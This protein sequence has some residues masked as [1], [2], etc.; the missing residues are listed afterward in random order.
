MTKSDLQLCKPAECFW[1]KFS[2]T[3]AIILGKHFFL[4]TF[5]DTFYFWSS[6]FAKMNTLFFHGPFGSQMKKMVKNWFV[7]QKFTCSWPLFSKLN[8]WGHATW[9][10][11]Y[12]AWFLGEIYFNFRFCQLP[13]C[14]YFSFK[15][16]NY[17]NC[18]W[19][20]SFCTY[21]FF[22]INIKPRSCF[23]VKS[24]C[25]PDILFNNSIQS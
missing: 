12:L 5:M 6:L 25:I 19:I 10:I 3:N 2:F 11:S 21:T 20:K 23:G 13:G 1:K 8:N 4:F 22:K 14:L 24:F 17:D 9:N 18:C 16:T 15:S 7:G